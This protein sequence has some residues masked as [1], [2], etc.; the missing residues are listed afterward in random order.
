MVGAHVGQEPLEVVALDAFTVGAGVVVDVDLGDWPALVVAERPAGRLLALDPQRRA[1]G[2]LGDPDIH[3]GHDRLGR[4][5]LAL[6][7]GT[8]TVFI[9]RQPGPFV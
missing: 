5:S 4:H 9:L 6:S 1:I 3:P 7:R 2:C 8:F